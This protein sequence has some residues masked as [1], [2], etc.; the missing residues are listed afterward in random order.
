MKD[1]DRSEETGIVGSDDEDAFIDEE[2]DDYQVS[3]ESERLA[4]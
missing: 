4:Q 1:L 2:D 3:R